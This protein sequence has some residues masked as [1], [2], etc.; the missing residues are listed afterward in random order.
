MVF[1]TF[2]K[3]LVYIASVAGAIITISGAIGWIYNEYQNHRRT[4][5][6]QLDDRINTLIENHGNTI[7]NEIHQRTDMFIEKLDSLNYRL[8]SIEG[9]DMFAVGFRA[10]GSG[11]L[12]YRDNLGKSHNVFYDELYD[13]YYYID[14]NQF[15]YLYYYILRP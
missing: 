8:K 7:L 6:E 12:Y 1:T 11:I 14:G 4:T 3:K 5:E 2:T 13:V 15:I 10:D 9:D